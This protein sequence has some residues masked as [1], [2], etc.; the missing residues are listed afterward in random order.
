MKPLTL[1]RAYDNVLLRQGYH[2]PYGA[3]IDEHGAM[4]E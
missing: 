2:T 1:V 4:V 3:V